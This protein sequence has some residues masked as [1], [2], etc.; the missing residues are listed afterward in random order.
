M[1]KVIVCNKYCGFY[2]S[3][4]KVIKFYYLKKK[5][6]YCFIIIIICKN[7]DIEIFL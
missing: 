7:I 1:S 3:Y 6:I 2:K 5:G 4:V